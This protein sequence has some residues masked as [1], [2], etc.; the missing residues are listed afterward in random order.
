MEPCS[1]YKPWHNKNTGKTYLLADDGKCLHYY[2]YFV[3]EELGLGYVRVPTWLPCRLQVYFNG[4]S[5][6][7][8]VLRKRK[9]HFQLIDNAFVEIADWGRARQIANGLDVRRLHHRLDEMARRFCPIHR[10]FGVAYHW[11]VDQCEYATDVVFRRQADLAAL[12]GN[13]TRTAIHTVKPDNIATFLGRKL[14]TQYE[15]EVGNRFNIRIEGTRIKHTMGPV[16]LKLYDKFGLILR[17]ETTVNDLTF[18]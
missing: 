1:T 2:F 10:D 18:F 9:I 15:G 4:H 6:L 11:S 7:A 8:S 5:W 17:I 16:S 14:N 3:D 12:Y 13:L